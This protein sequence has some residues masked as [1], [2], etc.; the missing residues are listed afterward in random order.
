MLPAACAPGA[1]TRSRLAASKP[2]TTVRIEL[3]RD[4]EAHASRNGVPGRVARGDRGRVAA[5]LQRQLADRAAE[6]DRVPPGVDV[7]RLPL[8]LLHVD[9]ARALLRLRRAREAAA[10]PV[11][12]P[13]DR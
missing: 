7:G 11:A 9:R 12:V 13:P 1:A 4:R 5:G 3:R 6:D 8:R 10:E 2:R